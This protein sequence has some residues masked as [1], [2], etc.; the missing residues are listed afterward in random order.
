MTTKKTSSSTRA[1]R[2]S[3]PKA[4]PKKKPAATAGR[5]DNKSMRVGALLKVLFE[6]KRVYKRELP[7]QLGVSMRTVNRYVA[8]LRRMDIPLVEEESPLGPTLRLSRGNNEQVHLALSDYEAVSL[9]IALQ[10]LN[11]FEGE[12]LFSQLD[13]LRQKLEQELH[14]ADKNNAREISDD[15]VK[16]RFLALSF[17]PPAYEVTQD[18][19]VFSSV[20]VAL[21]DE[22][23][24]EFSYSS[25]GKSSRKRVNPYT[26]VFY[27]GSFYLACAVEGQTSIRIYSLSRMSEVTVLQ[28]HECPLPKGYEPLSGFDSVSGMLPGELTWVTAS[29]TADLMEYLR[30]K[31][32][33][34]GTTLKKYR[35]RVT[36]R[37]HIHANEELAK[38][39]LGFGRKCEVKGPEDF[40]EMVLDLIHQSM[41]AY[42]IGAPTEDA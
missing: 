36:L 5:D 4:S 15:W 27:K 38:W 13:T 23:M 35:G 32:W 17:L 9:N 22:V 41:E 16:K 20:V 14:K 33:S 12:F 29:F 37:T 18:D 31:K 1:A 2:K 25:K 21:W 3:R 39:F 11:V 30:S 24:L 19:G 26:L 40:R 28:E 7:E 34:E 6:N 42:G 10:I 8:N